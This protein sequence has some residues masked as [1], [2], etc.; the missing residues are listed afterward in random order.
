M[1]SLR[2]RLGGRDGITLA[3]WGIL[4]PWSIYFSLGYAPNRTPDSLGNWILVGI[5]AHIVT[6]ITLLLGKVIFLRDKTKIKFFTTISIFIVAGIARG[7]A[8]GYFS[9]LFE[10]ATKPNYIPRLISAIYVTP[11][12]L[13]LSSIVV[14]SIRAHNRNTNNLVQKQKELARTKASYIEQIDQYRK[15]T[16]ERITEMTESALRQAQTADNLASGLIQASTEIVR[17]ISHQLARESV[18]LYPPKME[19]ERSENYVHW[20]S[21]LREISLSSAFPYRNIYFVVLISPIAALANS[22]GIFKGFFFAVLSML[23]FVSI[24]ACASKCTITWRRRQPSAI[25]F[26]PVFV[27]WILSAAAI[28]VF[29]RYIFRNIPSLSSTSTSFFV[30]AFMLSLLG[31]LYQGSTVLRQEIEAEMHAAIMA[32]IWEGSRARSIAQFEQD[33]FAQLVHGDIQS[34]V[35]ATAL[36]LKVKGADSQA[37]LD[38]LRE[39]LTQVIDAMPTDQALLDGLT[40][41]KD[42]WNGVC[43]I[44]IN[45]TDDHHEMDP[46]SAHGIMT[47]AREAFSNSVRHGKATEIELKIDKA[48]RYWEVMVTDNG[49]LPKSIR[50][51]GYGS[52]LFAKLAERYEIDSQNGRT[53]LKALIPAVK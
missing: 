15:A 51:R 29:A 9:V 12:W 41:I 40:S 53:V 52:E 10:A 18:I 36:K 42:V 7:L 19:S 27:V 16:K 35:T 38:E 23:I 2:E 26:I 14:A 44:Q 6:G 8:V 50:S 1:T 32:L 5:V 43:E 13:A 39:K 48:D 30:L 22:F 47:I 33:K 17:P 21:L 49:R 3:A 31:S 4:L 28:G 24:Q 20:K 37:S 45:V 11:V 34:V 25:A 46:Y